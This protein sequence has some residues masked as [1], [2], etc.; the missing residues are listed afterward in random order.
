[1]LTRDDLLALIREHRDSKVLSLYLNAEEH[2]PAKRRAWRKTKDHLVEGAR[3]R[4]GGDARSRDGFE[5]A[6]GH[7]DD[8][9]GQHESF[10]PERGWVG[11]AT[12]AGLIHAESLPVVMPNAARWADGPSVAAY[13]RALPHDVPVITALV[14]HRQAKLYRWRPG[15]FEEVAALQADT[16]FGDLSDN[17]NMSKRGTT[18]TGVRGESDTDVA[19]RLGQVAAERLLKNVV[20]KIAGHT[21]RD[22]RVVVGG[23]PETTAA[24]LSH[25]PKGLRER[26]IEDPTIDFYTTAAELGRATEVAAAALRAQARGRLVEQV[27]DL[28][29]AGG[30][31]CLGRQATERALAEQRVEVLLVNSKLAAADPE[32]MERYVLAAFEQSAAIEE[33]DGAAGERLESAGRGIGARLRFA[34]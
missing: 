18:H 15:S 6:C 2:D 16:A 13:A 29:G 30:R 4:L 3:A 33:V 21:G 7:L 25:L 23:P 34:T 1:M 27:V 22:G 5:R 14:D 28:A 24:T 31:A 12:S 20:E 26:A 19:N 8:V 17:V 9:L 10:L 32:A 11:F